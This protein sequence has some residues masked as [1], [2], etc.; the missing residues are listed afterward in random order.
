MFVGFFFIKFALMRSMEHTKF[1]CIVVCVSYHVV[2]NEIQVSLYKSVYKIVFH[3]CIILKPQ[4]SIC[5][6]FAV[7][8]WSHESLSFL[9]I[10][11]TKKSTLTAKV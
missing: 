9:F 10:P 7:L 1:S 3:F 8:H 11:E 5:Q 2:P 4:Y 6:S